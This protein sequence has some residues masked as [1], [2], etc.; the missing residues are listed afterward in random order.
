MGDDRP[1][2]AR[3]ASFAPSAGLLPRYPGPDLTP[4]DPVAGAAR[5]LGWIEASVTAE[6]RAAPGL[7]AELLRFQ[8]ELRQLVIANDPRYH[9]WG[10][11]DLLLGYARQEEDRPAT[12]LYSAELA[13]AVAQQLGPGERA[14]ALGA[15]AEAHRRLGNLGEAARHFAR[16]F[17]ELD[18]EGGGDDLLLRA[19]LLIGRARLAEQGGA[20]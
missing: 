19:H 17:T 1:G 3:P 15:L 12:A 9:R 13:L 11:F 18:A 6:R 10:L 4:P 20:L 2:E 7:V 16:A 8:R 14:A 5:R